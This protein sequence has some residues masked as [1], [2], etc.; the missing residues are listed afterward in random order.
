MAWSRVYGQKGV[1][2]KRA[3]IVES[4][5]KFPAFNTSY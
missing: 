5:K 1:S 4:Y 3:V 2:A